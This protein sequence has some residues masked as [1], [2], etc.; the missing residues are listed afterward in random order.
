MFNQLLINCHGYL[1]MDL[2]VPRPGQE[3]SIKKT[4]ADPAPEPIMLNLE[5]TFWLK[6][7]KGVQ[8]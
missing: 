3:G 6:I 7:N 4:F 8:Y 2:F 5:T 1:Q